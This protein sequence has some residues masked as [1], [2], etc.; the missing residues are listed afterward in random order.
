MLKNRHCEQRRPKVIGTRKDKPQVIGTERA[1]G[2]EFM[3]NTY[4]M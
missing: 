1:L 4:I 2:G 3:N